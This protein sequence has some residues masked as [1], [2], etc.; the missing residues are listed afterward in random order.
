[1]LFSNVIKSIFGLEKKLD[2]RLLP[3]QGYFYKKDFEIYIKKVDIEDIIIY[4]EK[5][6]PKDVL[7]VLNNMKNIV[8]KYTFFSE[9]YEYEDIKAVDI[10][11]IFIEIVKFTKGKDTKINYYTDNGKLL[12]ADFSPENFNY[13][14]FNEEIMEYYNEEERMFEA[15]GYKYTS[16]TIG[17]EDSLTNFLLTVKTEEEV[18]K[19]N[20]YFYDFTYFL[21]HK[22]NLEESEVDNLIHIFNYD[23]EKE[24]LN[25]IKNI[26]K[27]FKGISNYSIYSGGALIDLS[28]RLDLRDIWR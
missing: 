15:L 10:I 6:N 11:F 14:N 27:V 16:P 2:V 24:E 22:N 4:E 12:S 28:S 9:G 7:G 3:T 17:V 25:K 8:K 20:E 19:Y 5:Y 18:K 13:F 23:I 1:M 26:V 21:K